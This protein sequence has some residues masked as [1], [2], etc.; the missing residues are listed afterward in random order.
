MHAT[1]NVV[2]LR[3]PHPTSLDNDEDFYTRGMEL[4]IRVVQSLSL[5]RDMDTVQDIVRKA[6]RELT[7]ADGAT[8]VLRDNGQCYYVDE[9]AIEPLW[10]GKRFPMGLCI[11]GWAML[12]RQAVM[13]EDIYSDPRIP[14]EA[15]RPTFVKSLVMVP[16]RS[17]SPIGAIGN[18]WATKHTATRNEMRLLK[19]LADTTSVALENI[20]A[21]SNLEKKVQDRT[22]ELQTANEEIRRLALTDELT[23]SYNRRGFILLAEQQLKLSR[24]ANEPAQM[25]F[26]DLN[27]LKPVNDK[28]GHEK[29]DAMLIG[30]SEALR[31]CF[32]DTDVI[33]RLG[34]DEFCIFARANAE[35]GQMLLQ[36]LYSALKK[37]DSTSGLPP[38]SASVG[39]VEAQQHPEAPLEEL[40]SLSDAAMYLEKQ[41]VKSRDV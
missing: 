38:L 10:K 26:M 28:L 8:F 25:I 29:G 7:G 13:I 18:Y 34:G 36:R 23:R 17:S 1:S 31:K 37:F 4:L 14:V 12:N 20:E 41:K 39:V 33:G 30:L 3:S 5:A 11:S 27:G 9:D 6:A 22:A 2:Q 21:Y 16:I 19:A 40:I 32:R 24:L 15:Y 35:E